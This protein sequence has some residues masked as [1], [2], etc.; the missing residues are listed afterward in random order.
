MSINSQFAHGFLLPK[1]GYK[2]QG[3]KKC[4]F[5]YPALLWE[6]TTSG[7]GALCAWA[8]GCAAAGTG[9]DSQRWKLTAGGTET[10]IAHF[11]S[12]K[13]NAGP[14]YGR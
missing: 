4:A 12:Q 5:S 6:N 14:K 8:T 7:E 13:R 2:G 3:G 1:G 10:A 11:D 9:A